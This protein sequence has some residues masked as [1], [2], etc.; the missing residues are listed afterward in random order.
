MRAILP[1]LALFIAGCGSGTP[2]VRGPSDYLSSIKPARWN[3]P[4]VLYRVNGGS[5]E[6]RRVVRSGIHHWDKTFT[7]ILTLKEAQGSEVADINI[8]WVPVGSLGGDFFGRQTLGRTVPVIRSGVFESVTVKLDRQLMVRWPTLE[9]IAAHEFMHAMI[10]EG[11]S[12]HPEDLGY[13]PPAT[14]RPNQRDT[15]TAR[16]VYGF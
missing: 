11:H 4:V 15:N 9:R 5:S 3:K 7:G 16:K 2:T 10:N 12:P 6:V 13:S 1:L 8:E 14:S